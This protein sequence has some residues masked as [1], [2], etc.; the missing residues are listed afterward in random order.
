[1]ATITIR[2]IDEEMA[3]LLKKKAKQEGMSLNS[4]LLKILREALG[5]EKKQRRVIYTDLDHLAGGWSEEDYREF[6]SRVAEFEKV[7]EG[8]WKNN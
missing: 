4:V 2:G 5:L 8:M 1:M 3:K 7:E 6:E